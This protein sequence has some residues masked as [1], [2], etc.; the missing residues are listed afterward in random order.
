MMKRML[1]MLLALCLAL[2]L[3]AALADDPAVRVVGLKG[4]TAMG[5]VQMMAGEDPAYSFEIVS[6]IT[7]VTPMVARGEVDIAAVPANI[8]AVLYNNPDVDVQVLCVNTLG[9]LYIVERGDTIRSAADL[10]GRTIY[11]SGAGATP[12]F[13]LNYILA[14]NGITDVQIEWKS[15]HAECLAALLGDE[16]GIAMLPQPFVTTAMMRDEDLR[17]ALSLSDLWDVLQAGAEDPSM[18][19]TGVLI[20]RTA[21]AQEHPDLVNE[22]MDR[23]AASVAWVNENV[24]EAAALVGQFDIVPEAVALRA[25]PACNIVCIAGEDM[26]GALGGYLNVLFEANPR[27]VGGAV[28]DEGFWYLP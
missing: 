17:V 15:E 7:M 9:V 12:E 27:S 13:A 21:F 4:P 2:G 18:L 11:A 14:G 16:N 8:A 28:P 20:V 24:A 23:Y 5:M 3:G 1:S 6:D 10:A 25:I 22:F 19:I 26:V